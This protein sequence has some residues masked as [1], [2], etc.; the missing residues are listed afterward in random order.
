MR[1]P[2]VK[3]GLVLTAIALYSQSQ[4]SL[5]AQ[6]TYE[7]RPQIVAFQGQLLNCQARRGGIRITFKGTDLMPKARGEV[8]AKSYEGSAFIQGK[9]EN[10]PS[11]T[12]LGE[13]YMTY[14]LW[15][16]TAKDLPI[17]IGE[18]EIKDSR[19]SVE[20]R[21]AVQAVA[22]FITAEPYIE[23]SQPSN[24]VVLEQ[25]VPHEIAEANTGV[26]TKADLL[27]DA[28]APIG[29]TFEPLVVGIGQPRI[30]RQALNARRI[31]QIARA[32][33]YAP[34]EYREA[35]SLYQFVVGTVLE[36]RKPQKNDLMNAV[37]VIREYEEAR[38]VSIAQQNR[39]QR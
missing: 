10:L 8:N 35:E 37:T 30:F 15:T 22:L 24:L 27:R 2:L 13:Q 39:K 32:E 1:Y 29:Y 17:R 3:L 33:Q 4:E 11:P 25:V 21:T 20:T 23:V 38:A 28:Y 14:V 34:S 31:A 16:M 18:L 26:M 12:T 6:Q 9:F 7:Y 5:S 19:G 36:Q